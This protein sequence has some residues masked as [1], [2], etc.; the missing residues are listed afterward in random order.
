MYDPEQLLPHR[1]PFLFIDRVVEIDDASIV[2]VRKFRQEEEFFA[3][4][5]ELPRGEVAE[6]ADTIDL[7]ADLPAGACRLSLAVMDVD[8][9]E[10]VIRLGIK[11]RAKDGWYPLS[12][13]QVAK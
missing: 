13:L 2:A 10:P 4:H 8:S 1:P 6:V 9:A 11:G 3:G 5:W 12:E 7:P